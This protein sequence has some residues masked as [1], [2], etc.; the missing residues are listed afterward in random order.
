MNIKELKRIRQELKDMGMSAINRAI[1]TETII[2][3]CGDSPQ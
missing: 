2:E 1:V 3:I